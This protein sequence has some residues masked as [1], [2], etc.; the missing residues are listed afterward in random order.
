MA[1]QERAIVVGGG[2]GG[3]VGAGGARGAVGRGARGVCGQEVTLSVSLR[4]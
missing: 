2:I 1:Q 3:E 4:L